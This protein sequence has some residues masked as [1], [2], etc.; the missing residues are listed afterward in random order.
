MHKTKESKDKRNSEGDNVFQSARD[1]EF[2]YESIV[3]V[4]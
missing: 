1:N 4:G 2:I 3:L